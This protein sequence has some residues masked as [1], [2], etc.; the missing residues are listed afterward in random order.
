MNNLSWKEKATTWAAGITIAGLIAG[1]VSSCSDRYNKKAEEAKRA[2]AKECLTAGFTANQ[3]GFLYVL[4]KKAES[5]ADTAAAVGM[6]GGM[7]I[8]G[9]MSGGKK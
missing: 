9:T 4:V 3:C 1:G 6:V 8:G 7:A 2:W 5:D